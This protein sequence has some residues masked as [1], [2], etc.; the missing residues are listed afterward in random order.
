VTALRRLHLRD[1]EGFTLVELLIAMIV[2]AVGILALVGAYTSSYVN[3]NRATRVSSAEVLT[4]AQMERFRALSYSNIQLNT[5]CG[6]SCTEDSTYTSDSVYSSPAQVTGCSTT[7]ATCLPTQTKT[8]PD[9][10]SYRLDTY[11]KYSCLSGTLSTSPS[12]TCGSTDPAPVKLVTVVV[13]SIGGGGGGA[14]GVVSAREQSA[15]TSLTG[16]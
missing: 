7:D 13:H 15:F 1:E 14:F 12:L 11:I 16:Q 8:G 4:N 2:L 5:T 9:G 3:L 6:A 10:N